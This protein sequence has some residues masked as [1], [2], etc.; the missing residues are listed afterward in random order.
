MIDYLFNFVKF[1][2]NNALFDRIV[3]I[4]DQIVVISR[5]M[6]SSIQWKIVTNN[7]FIEKKKEKK[8]DQILKK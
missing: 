5:P 4:Y 1:E 3:I 8:L 7:F 6:V 2:K